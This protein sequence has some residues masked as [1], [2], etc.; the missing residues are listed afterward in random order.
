MGTTIK[1]NR[2]TEFERQLLKELE[3]LKEKQD[4]MARRLDELTRHMA[5][6][7]SAAGSEDFAV[8][9]NDLKRRALQSQAR[10][11]RDKESS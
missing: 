9:L 4:Y 1:G 2:V 5:G 10:G 11:K 6:S 7:G 3:T 8:K